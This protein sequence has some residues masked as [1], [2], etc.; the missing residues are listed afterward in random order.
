MTAAIRNPDVGK[1][2]RQDNLDIGIA[3]DKGHGERDG[4]P[5]AP[6]D[7]VEPHGPRPS[8][9]F[10]TARAPSKK[11]PRSSETMGRRS[12]DGGG[13]GGGPVEASAACAVGDADGASAWRLGADEAVA[14]VDC[15]GGAVWALGAALTGAAFEVAA[16]GGAAGHTWLKR[17]AGGGVPYPAV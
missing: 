3:I 17:V 16:G 9:R 4:R 6:G 2:H 1:D 8:L 13:A 11:R 15:N 7:W 14:V 12:R 5:R 10:H